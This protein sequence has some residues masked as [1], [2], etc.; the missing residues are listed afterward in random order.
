MNILIST[1][2]SFSRLIILLQ[3]ILLLFTLSACKGQKSAVPKALQEYLNNQGVQET[4]VDLDYTS[5]T[6]PDKRYVSITVTYNFSTSS[7][8]PQKEYLGFV[9][10]SDGGDWQIDRHTT[11]TVNQQKAKDLLA[12]N[13]K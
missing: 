2:I 12:G 7:G 6:V 8:K 13:L 11:Y 5:P 3:L 10:K 4:L 1:H 9:L